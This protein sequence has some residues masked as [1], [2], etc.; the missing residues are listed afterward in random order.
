MVKRVVIRGH[1]VTLTSKDGKTWVTDPQ[2]A[3]DFVERRE[4]AY[5]CA[6]WWVLTYLSAPEGWRDVR[7]L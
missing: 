5:R 3:K 2:D 6:R 4:N 1:L 7:A